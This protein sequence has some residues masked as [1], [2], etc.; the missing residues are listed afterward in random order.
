[1]DNRISVVSV[2]RYNEAQKMAEVRFL[3]GVDAGKVKRLRIDPEQ[4]FD[5]VELDSPAILALARGDKTC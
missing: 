1:L 3:S 2:E 4:R 5:C